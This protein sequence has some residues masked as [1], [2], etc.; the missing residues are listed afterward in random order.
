KAGKARA[1]FAEAFAALAQEQPSPGLLLFYAGFARLG[2]GRE[3][4]SAAN[5]AASQLSGTA[6]ASARA[7]LAAARDLPQVE[8]RDRIAPEAAKRTEATRGAVRDR[9]LA[10]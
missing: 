6:Q 4:Y 5:Q 2:D 1:E 9:L 3:G 7:A 8:L 10:D